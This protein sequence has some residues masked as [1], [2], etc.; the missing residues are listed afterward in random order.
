M[1]LQA[2]TTVKGHAV[3]DDGGQVAVAFTTKDGGELSIMLAVDC[4][5]SP[6]FGSPSR[7][8]GRKKQTGRQT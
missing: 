7:Q 6:H 1:P 2:V 5:E 8:I 3:S 4:L